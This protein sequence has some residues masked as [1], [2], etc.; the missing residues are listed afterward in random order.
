MATVMGRHVFI[1]VLVD[2][3]V[4]EGVWKVL[5]ELTHLLYENGPA[6]KHRL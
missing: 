6:E 1:E 3:T 5:H 4:I 2:D